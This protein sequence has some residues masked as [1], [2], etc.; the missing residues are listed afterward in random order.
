LETLLV[1]RNRDLDFHGGDWAF[2]GGA[3][4]PEDGEPGLPGARR[5]AVREIAEEVGLRIDADA[6]VPFSRWIAP[7]VL[8][9]R[10]DA[11]YF[12]ARAPDVP[13]TADGSELVT[14][15]FVR[16]RDVL[17]AHARSAIGLPPPTYVTL[18]ELDAFATVDDALTRWRANDVRSYHPRLV[19]VE[20]GVCSLYDD[21]AG[22]ADC[23][24]DAPGPRHR[25]WMVDRPWRYEA[26]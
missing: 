22:Y 17:V 8:P 10:F 23:S 18:V 4:E 16:P 26:P 3:L 21:D 7:D 2:P 24:L 25:L 13:P 6:L 15:R 5:G 11:W 19:V 12:A 20:G 1:E 9:K 14:C